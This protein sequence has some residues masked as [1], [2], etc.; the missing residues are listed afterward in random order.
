M[1]VYCI[2]RSILNKTGGVLAIN[3]FRSVA[4]LSTAIR[5]SSFR[6]LHRKAFYAFVVVV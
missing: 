4:L 3:G 1:I 2:L 5:S 6:P